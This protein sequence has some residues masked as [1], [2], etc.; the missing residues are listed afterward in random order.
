MKNVPIP[1]LVQEFGLPTHRISAIINLKATE[2]AM[3]ATGRYDERVDAQLSEFYSGRF[4]SPAYG[5]SAMPAGGRG[6]DGFGIGNA[7][8]MLPD[9]VEPEDAMP[10]S[11]RARSR[12]GA[13]TVFRIGH[14][15]SKLPVPPKAARVHDSKFVFRDISGRA[16]NN[17]RLL[18][19][20]VTS[21]WDGATR[22]A[23]NQ[24]TLY[25]SWE[26]RYWTVDRASKG[27]PE[28]GLPYADADAEKPR[29]KNGWRVPP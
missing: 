2:P 7:H 19:P 4:G 25:R 14:G 8:M 9:D 13:G 16:R 23:T 3:R 1:K 22:P 17:A 21:D 18:N 10:P 15:L 29:A 26:A 5:A 12:D 20:L 28:K 6:D 11:A 27:S 24:E